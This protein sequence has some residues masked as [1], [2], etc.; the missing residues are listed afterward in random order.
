MEFYVVRFMTYVHR[1][2]PEGL[3]CCSYCLIFSQYMTP[4]YRRIWIDK[5]DNQITLQI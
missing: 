5:Y 3:H 1:I 2:K 4:I